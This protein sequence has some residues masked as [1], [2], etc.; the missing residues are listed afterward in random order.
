VEIAGLELLWDKFFG[1]FQRTRPII[2]AG[3]VYRSKKDELRLA[4]MSIG[5]SSVGNVQLRGIIERLSRRP[6]FK[7]DIETRDLS[8]AGFYD[9]FIRDTYRRSH[10]TLAKLRIGGRSS[11]MFQIQ[12][13]LDAFDAAGE[14]RLDAAEIREE[15]EKWRLGPMEMSLPFGLR[16]PEAS[17]KHPSED[18][19]TGRL[20]VKTARVGTI[21]VPAVSA[22]FRLWNNSLSIIQPIVLSMDGGTMAV[23][24]LRWKDLVRSPEDLSFSVELKDIRLLPLTEALGWSRF[25]GTLSGSIPDVQWT[26]NALRSKGKLTLDVF[27]GRLTVDGLEVLNPFTSLPS[28]KTNVRLKEIDLDRATEAFEFGRISG[29][30]EGTIEDLVVT[31]GQAAQ[32]RAQLQTLKQQGVRQWISVEALNKISVL[33]SGNETGFIYSGLAKLFDSYRYHKLGFTAHLRNDRLTLSGIERKEGKEYLVVGTLLPPTVNIISH[34]QEISFS[35]LMRRIE[36]VR[37]AGKIQ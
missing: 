9:F 6:S 19:T 29:I 25:R 10:P 4:P 27:G 2:E 35:E 14:M 24:N 5:L 3:G 12:G 16:Y 18:A 15:S 7:L 33:S 23:R 11:L 37:K 36:R 34:T 28:I 26:G 1:D 21:T 13:S 30:L 31:S 22:S 8:L 20:V 32:F 17:R